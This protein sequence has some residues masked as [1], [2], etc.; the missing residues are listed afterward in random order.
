[1]LARRNHC[2]IPLKIHQ[3][4]LHKGPINKPPNLAM[5]AA[6][7]FYQMFK[8]MLDLMIFLLDDIRLFFPHGDLP[9]KVLLSD[10]IRL[11][12]IIKPSL[13]QLILLQGIDPI[14]LDQEDLFGF[15]TL[16]MALLVPFAFD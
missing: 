10:I 14:F 15:V 11:D 1:L 4:F 12:Q 5:I 7:I 9:D 8:P 2:L 16:A 13:G 3:F 6:K